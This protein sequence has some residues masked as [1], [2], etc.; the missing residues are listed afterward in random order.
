[1]EQ[2]ESIEQPNRRWLRVAEVA[3]LLDVHEVSIRKL[4]AR[5]AIPFIRLPGVEKGF[6][7]IRIDW[8]RFQEE[9]ERYEARPKN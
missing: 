6:R 4:V 5:K 8:K 7:S 1:M 3:R 2:I 9:L